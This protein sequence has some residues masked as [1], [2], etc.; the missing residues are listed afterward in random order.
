VPQEFASF[1]KHSAHNGSG[2]RFGPAVEGFWPGYHQRLRERLQREPQTSKGWLSP[3]PQFNLLLALRRVATMSI[4]VPLPLASAVFVCLLFSIFFMMHS[5]QSSGTGLILTPPSVITQTIEV[6]V[7]QEKLVT[8]VVYRKVQ[9]PPRELIARERDG[10]RAND[11][12]QS[13]PPLTDRSLEGFKPANDAKLTIIK[14][15]YRDEK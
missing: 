11:Y 15:S 4:P 9:A 14:G 5:R 8:R 10:A 2:D 7:I 1:A 6:P 3:P 13:D 12:R